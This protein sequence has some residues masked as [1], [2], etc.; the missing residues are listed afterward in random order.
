MT[1]PIR[2]DVWSDIA[3]PWCFI[4]KRKFEAGAA[5]FDGDVEIV[6][7]SF[8]LSPETP[9]DYAGNTV[10]YLSKR[11]GIP[12]EQAQQ[13][14]DSVVAVAADL[15]LNYDYDTV[16]PT[17]TGQAHELLHLAREKGVQLGLVERLFSAYFEQ[18]RHLG[19]LDELV[20][21]AAEVGVDPD[22]ARDALESGQ[23]R[24]AV[25]ADIDQA[26][27]YGIGGV[28]F[29]VIDGKLGVSGAQ[30]PEVFTQAL[31]RV[32]DEAITA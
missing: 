13:M 3:C 32:R 12:P 20:A 25:D 23:Y 15:G 8:Q 24:A 1:N 30:S 28:P 21:L 4:G 9:A 17:N 7:H 14:V 2:V 18:G 5:A 6:Y 27:E 22:E 26:A 11:K 31:E 29:Y 16:R 19:N 10:D